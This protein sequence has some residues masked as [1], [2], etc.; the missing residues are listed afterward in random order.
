MMN[1]GY[2]CLTVGVP[3]TDFRSCIQKNADD[4]RLIGDVANEKERRSYLKYTEEYRQG[5]AGATKLKRLLW[6]LTE[7]Y[8][9]P[10][11]LN[12]YYFV[13]NGEESS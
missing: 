5:S 10:Y 11:L 3:K 4:E 6:K 8:Q 12:S 1:I 7:K 13:L 9:E 2:A